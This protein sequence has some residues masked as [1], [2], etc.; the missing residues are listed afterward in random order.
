MAAVKRLAPILL[1][2]LLCGCP[3]KP[4]ASS[5]TAHGTPASAAESQT[6][7]ALLLSGSAESQWDSE[8]LASLGAELKFDPYAK[9]TAQGHLDLLGPYDVKINDTPVSLAICLSGLTAL[10]GIQNQQDL[11]VEAQQW[12]SKQNAR[13]VWLDG[14]RAQFF[15]GRDLAGHVPILFT[16]VVADRQVYYSGG[17]TGVYQR[18]ALTAL[19]KLVW[20]RAP[21]AHRF[22]LVSDAAPASRD[23]QQKFHE[24]LRIALGTQ[25]KVIASEPVADWKA[26]HQ[27]LL[28]MQTQVDAVIVAGL[29][30]EEGG[31]AF[32][33][34][35]PR[36]LL[37]GI[38]IPVIAVGNS[39]AAGCFPVNVRLRTSA[40][41]KTAIAMAAQILTGGDPGGIPT[42]TPDD[43]QV[44]VNEK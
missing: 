2:L 39:P 18:P 38:S 24:L 9:R 13:L 28:D 14:D 10:A 16:G 15:I 6:T 21:K 31:E 4:G 36:D 22:A 44:T 1:L 12:L 20:D 29:G 11:A 17:A 41:V 43:M 26:L 5:A 40:H 33:P 3:G 37:A 34:P 32:K 7:V 35:C 23:R 8:L 25:G 30:E 42:V 27:K 19:L